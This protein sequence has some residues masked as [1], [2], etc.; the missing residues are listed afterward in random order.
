MMTQGYYTGISGIQANQYGLDVIADNL[1]NTNTVGF[2][3]SSTEFASLFSEKLV[4][5]G[6]VPTYDEIGAGTRLQATT[7][8]TQNGSLLNTDRFNDLAINGNGWFGVVSGKDQYF[9]RAGNF[10][11]DEVQK[12][13]GDVNSSVGRL[14]TTEGMYVTGTMMNNFAYDSQYNYALQND[15]TDAGAFKITATA[16]TVPL[17][18]A[19]EQGPIELPT[20]LAYPTEP[21]TSTKFYGNLGTDVAERTMSANAISPSN[22]QNRIKL[23]FTQSAVQPEQGVSW[24]VVATATSNDGATMYDTQHG[25]AVFDKRGALESFNLPTINNDGA[26]V[27]VDLGSAF[28]GLISSSGPT[29]SAS[30]QSDGI[31]GGTLNQYSINSDGIVIADFSNGKQS[32]IGR[33]AVYHFQNDQGLTRTGSTLF[34]QSDNSGNPMFWTDTNGEAVTGTT[35]SSGHLENSN[36]R[37]EVGLT[38][39][40]VMQRAYQAN[41]KTVTTVDEMIQKAL[42]MRK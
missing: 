41:A 15:V 31:S 20:R 30:S 5:S 2:R 37:M 7:M 33:I 11:L 17:A 3:G 35:I 24:D 19:N 21:T 8:N 38:D 36:V 23:V 32:A 26:P 29:I 4:S 42:S 40:I 18:D 13:A 27:T 1:A 12:T 6:S 10:V 14:T 16:N 39:M 22:D 25:T 9:T 28:G 34:S